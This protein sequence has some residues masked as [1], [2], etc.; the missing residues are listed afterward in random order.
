MINSFELRIGSWVRVTFSEDEVGFGK[1]YNSYITAIQQMKS[2][3]FGDHH[4][5]PNDKL[6][7]IPLTEDILLKCG[8]EKFIEQGSDHWYPNQDGLWSLRLENNNPLEYIFMIQVRVD[9]YL[10]LDTRYRYLH[11]LQNLYF[12]LTGEELNIS[13]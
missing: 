1:D 7:P 9:E 11:Q 12:T 10:K 8:F 3:V 13:L 2:M 4:W 5:H 6:E